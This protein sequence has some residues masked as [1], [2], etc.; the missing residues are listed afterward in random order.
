M[1]ILIALGAAALLTTAVSAPAQAAAPKYVCG[2][3]FQ[4]LKGHDW[5]RGQAPAYPGTMC[6][7]VLGIFGGKLEYKPARLVKDKE[8]GDYAYQNLPEGHVEHYAAKISKDVVF[9]STTTCTGHS[10]TLYLGDHGMGTKKCSRDVLL[11]RYRSGKGTPQALVTTR[12]GLV[13]R[14]VELYSA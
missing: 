8:T 13:V 12:K 4:T 14:V 3:K 11:K 1:R 5:T 6:A 2:K 9:L 10:G 7:A